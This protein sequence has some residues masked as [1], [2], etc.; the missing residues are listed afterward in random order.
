M[1]QCCRKSRTACLSSSCRL[2][3]PSG[4]FVLALGRICP[5]KGFHHALDAAALAE[6]PLLL[7]GK[8]YPYP[9]HLRYFAEELQPRLGS[10]ARFL[11]P[12]S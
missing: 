3:T 8:V 5:E 2:G 10:Q 4:D 11:G 12:L 1:R 9:D 6:T 7:A